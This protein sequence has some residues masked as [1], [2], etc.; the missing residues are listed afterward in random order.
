MHLCRSR[1]QHSFLL[2]YALRRLDEGN[3]RHTDGQ[4]ARL[5]EHDRISLGESFDV[6]AALDENAAFSRRT[7]GRRNGRGRRELQTAREVDEQQ[8]EH[9]LPVTRRTID[10]GRTEE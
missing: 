2:L 10:D 6:I 5:I 7:N 9:A 3:L 8:V 1:E 4:R